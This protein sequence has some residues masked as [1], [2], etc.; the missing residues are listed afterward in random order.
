MNDM[1]DTLVS[2]SILFLVITLAIFTLKKLRQP[3]QVAYIIAGIIL[4]P[5]LAFIFSNAGIILPVT[6]LVMLLN[7]LF[8]AVVFR[9]L[10]MNWRE[11]IINGSLLSQTGEFA[12]L[13]CSMAY[14]MNLVSGDTFRFAVAVTGLSLLFSTTYIAVAKQLVASRSTVGMEP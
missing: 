10:K 12:L 11:S 8:S 13:A 14:G 9:C 6:L 4:G 2:F 5:Y 7:S 3:Y 1:H